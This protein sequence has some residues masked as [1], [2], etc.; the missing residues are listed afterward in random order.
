MGG[1]YVEQGPGELRDGQT[2]GLT[3]DPVVGAVEAAV[4]HPTTNALWI[5]SVNGG[6]WRTLDASVASPVWV[7]QTPALGSLS[8]SALAID[9]TDPTSNTLVAGIDRTSSFGGNGGSR[10]GLL[11]TTDGGA[12]WAN[13]GNIANKGISGLAA[14]G[15]TIVAA[16]S[17]STPFTFPN[18]GIFRST[19]TGATFTQV[20]G[21]FPAAAAID[22]ASDPVNAG[23]TT[24]QL[25]AVTRFGGASSGIYR[26]NDTGA[27]WIK[28]SNATMDAIL[29]A[30]DFTRGEVAV[31]RKSPGDPT[32]SNVAAALCQNGR[33]SGLFYSGNGGATWNTLTLPTTNDSTAIGLHPGGQCGTHLS[34]TMDP[35]SHNIF[36]VGGDRQPYATE[37]VMGGTF[38]PNAVG[39]LNFTGRLYR[40][41][42]VANTFAPITHCVTG[43]P[44][45]CGGAQRTTLNSAPH[46]D[47]RE[48]VFLAN[49]ELIETDDGGVYRRTNPTGVGDWFSAVGSLPVAEQHGTT[50]D[51]VSNI[52]FSGNQDTGS[53]EQQTSGGP[54]WR[55]I[56][57]GDGGDTAVGLNDPVAGQSTR[58]SSAQNL[59]GFVRQVF[60]SAN[61]MQSETFPA[62]T[63]TPACAPQFVTPIAVNTQTP[64]RLIIGCNNGVYE[65]NDR[66]DTLVQRSTDD[67]TASGTGPAIAYGVT[68]NADALYYAAG[69]QVFTRTAAPPTAPVGSTPGG[70]TI[71][72]VAIDSANAANGFALSQTQVSRTTTAGGSWS[73]ITGN[74]FAVAPGTVLRSMTFIKG[75][76][77][78]D[79]LAV[80]TNNGVYIARSDAGFST[81]QPL[82]TGLPNAPVFDLQYDSADDV[83]LAGTL[84]RGA[85]LVSGL[86]GTLPVELIW[87]QVD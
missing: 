42:G 8:I 34:I 31:G 62:L 26:S 40:I 20:A 13:I 38:F 19:D 66:G 2:E 84:G 83:L 73:D 74:L 4:A 86:Q 71:I 29:A 67:V 45:G 48:M 36:Y 46:A 28:V 47:S 1:A 60:N 33:L 68:G 32:G 10:L 12:N 58:Y 17:I 76:S 49:G 6:I 55:T 16:I 24:S 85:W 75:T 15:A 25:F 30:A 14:R 52:V 82:G 77:G 41:D 22:L 72:A 80:G 43:A 69:A 54:I 21:G 44:S 23:A 78:V 59:G 53:G 7:N 27:T 18:I 39:A 87:Y 61:V 79:G 50:Y 9:P 56:N 81:W 51:T 64:S 65:S 3:N 57:Q 5:G 11:R 35:T 70:G 63:A 37:T